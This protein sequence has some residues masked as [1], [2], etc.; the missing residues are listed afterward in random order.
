M[1]PRATL[2]VIIAIVVIILAYMGLYTVREGQRAIVLQLGKIVTNPSTQQAEVFVPGLHFKVPLIT[3]VRKF[4]IRLQTLNVDSSRILTAEQKYVLVDYYAKWKIDNLPLY[5]KR[6]G[7]YISRTQNLLKQKI[8]NALRAAFG[9]RTIK[10]VVSGER[11]NVMQLLKEKANKSAR[12]LGIK[13]VDVRIKGI[14]LPKEVRDSVFQRMSTEREQVATK[15]RAQ[16]QAAAETV[17]ASADATVAVTLAKAKAQSQGVRAEGDSEAAEVY[18]KAYNK[19]PKFYAFYRSLKAY[20]QVFTN[21][22][23][24]MILRPTGE[25]FKYFTQAKPKSRQTKG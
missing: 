10:E 5:Y 14:D 20:R 24:V 16:G 25:F 13:V 21:K 18:I 22:D 19:D 12:G 2:A 9:K 3:R 6:T 23:T 11:L 8:N 1:S 4:D 15:H 17:R 7:G